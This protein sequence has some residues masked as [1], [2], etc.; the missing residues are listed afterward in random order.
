MTSSITLLQVLR[1]LE[2]QARQEPRVELAY[3]DWDD[4]RRRIWNRNWAPACELNLYVPE[5]R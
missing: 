4:Y 1:Q 2:E 3:L 5:L